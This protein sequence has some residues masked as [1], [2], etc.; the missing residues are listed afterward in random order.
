LRTPPLRRRQRLPLADNGTVGSR[1]RDLDRTWDVLVIG[2]GAFGC[3]VAREAALNGLDVALVERDDLAEGT[4]SRSS[5][6]IH[7]GLRYLE[8]LEF[9]LVRQALRERSVLEKLAPQLVRPCPFLVPILD[10]GPRGRLKTRTGLF[11]Y[12]LLAGLPRTRRRSMHGAAA[13]RQLEPGLV[14]EGLRGGGRFWDWLT[15]DSR[16]VA[17]V[18]AAAGRAGA[19]I[20][21]RAEAR[22]PTGEAGRFNVEV[23]DR[24]DGEVIQVRAKTVI[25]TVGPWSDAFRNANGGGGPRT[26]LTSGTHIV[27]PEVTREHA[28]VVNARSD[29]RVFFLLPFFGHTLIGTTDRDV[30]GAPEDVTPTRDDIAY[31]LEE[32]N[33]LLT[34][35]LSREDVI[36][37]FAG[38]RTLA[39]D[40]HATPSATSR[41]QQVW[42]EPLGVVHVVGGKLTTW[43]L[44]ARELLE[45]AAARA[46]LPLDDGTLSATTSITEPDFAM[47]TTL[48][49]D[50][51]PSLVAIARRTHAESLVDVLRR[52]TPI[53]LLR[54]FDEDAVARLAEAL[55]DA[56][57]WDAE[58]RRREVSEVLVDPAH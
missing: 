26:R 25:A 11:L 34:T 6:M 20:I 18:A 49:D 9:G 35:R 56:A 15:Y 16:L 52:R 39:A 24:R 30:S 36:S 48:D 55:G 10:G 22:P 17:E 28:I 12:D 1:I 58:R 31:L 37:A 19:T 4:S 41:E 44:I 27:V 3:G 47:P 23:E 38:V 51:I 53:Q 50:T 45:R 8:T 21:T 13:L 46:G 43:R 54:T 32:T 5:K 40:D 7:G 14:G 2:G 29:R 57:G 33:G 42:E